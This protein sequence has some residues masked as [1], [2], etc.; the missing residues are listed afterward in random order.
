M[1]RT[2]HYVLVRIDWPTS[3]DTDMVADMVEAAIQT[4]IDEGG[5]EACH[6]NGPNPP[7]HCKPES[8]DVYPDERPK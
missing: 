8:F 7:Y 5:F 4:A 2:D 6:G 1:T 3:V